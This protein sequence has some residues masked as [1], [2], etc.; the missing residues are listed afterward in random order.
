[1]AN[2][3]VRCALWVRFVGALCGCAGKNDCFK[4]LTKAERLREALHGSA[5][6]E[7]V[8]SNFVRRSENDL[9]CWGTGQRS[10]EL[11][12]QAAC[13]QSFQTTKNDRDPRTEE[14]TLGNEPW[15][16]PIIV[17]A[18]HFHDGDHAEKASE[19]GSPT[20]KANVRPKRGASFN[21]TMGGGLPGDFHRISTFCEASM[22]VYGRSSRVFL[23]LGSRKRRGS[24]G[25]RQAL[26]YP[27]GGLAFTTDH[28]RA[29]TSR[30]RPQPPTVL[31]VMTE[32]EADAIR[33]AAP[34][35]NGVT[36]PIVLHRTVPHVRTEAT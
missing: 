1:M 34:A 35:G 21:C 27:P 31:R 2:S 6:K 22:L 15:G 13:L 5:G 33:L 9:S 3:L 12:Q 26:G 20:K 14:K 19:G 24:N 7:P 8:R 28:R 18:R 32:P 23:S 10:K 30:T 17:Q 25:N 4:A 11:R 36:E 29:L 16:K